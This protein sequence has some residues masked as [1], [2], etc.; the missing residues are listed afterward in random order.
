MI[1]PKPKNAAKGRWWDQGINIVEDCTPVSTG[2]ANCWHRAMAKRF[3]GDGVVRFRAD[4]LPRLSAGKPCVVAVWGDLF[5]SAVADW[6]I[7]DALAVMAFTK[8]H[9]YVVL[10]KRIER[11]RAWRDAESFLRR[12]N[13]IFGTSAENQATLDERVPH[14]LA[15][16]AAYRGL[17]LEP[18]LERVDVGLQSATCDCCERW[19]SRWVRLLRPVGPDIAALAGCAAEHVAD[20]GVYRAAGNRHGAL[21]VNTPAGLLGIKPN[22]F[23]CLP[24]IDWVVV[25]AETGPKRRPCKIEWI[26][27]VV[28]QCRAAGVPC[29]VKGVDLGKRV[30]HDPAEWPAELTRL[31]EMRGWVG[32]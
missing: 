6:Q 19:P 14:I 9:G 26:I 28:E 10:T 22:E 27:D 5:H 25:G 3:G 23:E 12:P 13:I 2:C 32:E 1:R 30:S 11:L 17:S 21:S 31:G 20:S 15:T 7:R 29:W 16:P 18:L 24:A 4:R 8:T